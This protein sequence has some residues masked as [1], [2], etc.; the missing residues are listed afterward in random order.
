VAAANPGAF[1]PRRDARA[2]E[3]SPV[4]M[5]FKYN[6][7]SSSSMVFV[8]RKYGGRIEEV[9]RILL[10]RSRTRGALMPTSPSPHFS[11]IVGASQPK[12]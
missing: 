6:H 3:K 9:K 8:R 1:R 4:E 5:P 10:A 7:G 12:S 2:S 11:Q